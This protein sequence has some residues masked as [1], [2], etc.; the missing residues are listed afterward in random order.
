[1]SYLTET[2][3]KGLLIHVALVKR[4][5]RDQP[6][7][8]KTKRAKGPAAAMYEQ[9][10]TLTEILEEMLREHVKVT[11]DGP[12]HINEARAPNMEQSKDARDAER[13]VQQM[14]KAAQRKTPAKKK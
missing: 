6:K 7:E 8:I 9:L 13:H 3:R 5:M 11:P 1:M 2:R 12:P 4:S 10:K 14:A